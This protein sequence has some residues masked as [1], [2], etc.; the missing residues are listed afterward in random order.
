MID[1]RQIHC[2]SSLHDWCGVI[3]EYEGRFFRALLPRGVD[4]FRRL[5]RDE[6]MECLARKG[7][8]RMKPADLHIPGYPEVVELERHGPILPPFFWTTG[9]LA[10]AGLTICRLAEELLSQ[11]LIIWDLKGMTNMTFS[12]TRGPL[13]LDM[14]AIYTTEELENRVLTISVNSLYDQVVTSFYFPLWLAYGPLRDRR[15]AKR[16]ITYHRAGEQGFAL[17]TS[18]MRRMTLGNRFVPG[19]LKAR[20]LL[21]SR[22][23]GRFFELVGRRVEGWHQRSLASIKTENGHGVRE[24]A[25]KRDPDAFVQTLSERWGAMEGKIVFDLFP[26]GRLGL[27]L[28]E[29]LRA[30]VYLVTG[31]SEEADGYYA[32]R[33]RE[34]RP[35]LPVLCD[36]WDRYFQH[37]CL[38][39]KACDIV[40]IF[41]DVVQTAAANRVP[42]DHLG[43]VLSTLTRDVAIV[44]VDEKGEET[45]FPT[46][47]SDSAPEGNRVS[48]V[49]AIL[50]KYFRSHEVVRHSSLAE[51]ALLILRK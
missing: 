24:E 7:L 37:A 39:E 28:A 25:K 12:A 3:F 35:V 45:S 16:L 9:M 48:F 5:N 47:V 27:A 19:L 31:D 6:W 2:S 49:L 13:L 4:L 36:I 42:L 29:R 8:S 40:C 43:R 38:F 15:F 46:F 26:R 20:R 14:G 44:S 34:E 10:E 21:H 50:G 32:W 17:T 33:M 30:T 41:P 23:Y 11:G 18:L 1:L 22:H 51:T